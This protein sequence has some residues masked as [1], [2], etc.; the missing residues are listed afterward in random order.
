[1]MLGR[2]SETSLEDTGSTAKSAF[3][4]YPAGR[5]FAAVMTQTWSQTTLGC[6]FP[7][8]PVFFHHLQSSR[9]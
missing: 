6:D 2:K 1:M 8:Y 5:D 3:R 7:A 9:P 4:R